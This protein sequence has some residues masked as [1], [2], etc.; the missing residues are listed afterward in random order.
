MQQMAVWCA[1]NTSFAHQTA[2]TSQTKMAVQLR[3][4]MEDDIRKLTLP[5]GIPNRVE[6]LISIVR[7]TFQL[8]GE[9]RLHYEDK[10]FNNQFF[11]VTSTADLYDKATVKIEVNTLKRK[12][13]V[14]AVPS[15]NVK[16]QKKAE[17]N[18]LPPHPIGESQDTLDKERL[19]LLNEVKKKNN[20][21][22]ITYKMRKTFSSRRL[23]VVTLRPSVNV[24]KER[25]PALFSEA[26]IKKEFRRITTVS[27]EDKFMK[28][29]DQ[30]TPGL[31]RVMRAK[32]GAAG[33]K[34]RPLLDTVNDTQI[35]EKK[36]DAVVCC[37]I[38]YFGEKR[39][40]LFYDCKECEDFTD[41]TIQVI[42]MHSNMAVEDP[43]D[44]S[45]VIEGNQ[46]MEGCGS[47]TKAC[48]LLMGLIY[49]LNLEYPKRLKNTFETFQKIFLELDRD[50]LPK[51]VDS[52]KKK[53]MQ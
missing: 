11:S 47:R 16:K 20:A 22:I 45:I 8:P 14:D 46:V 37:L 40:D 44:V 25:W 3:V 33:S 39:E 12:H 50:N 15:K 21:K 35:I 7:E 1:L 43:S 26:Q 51:K 10:E 9:F 13:P 4:I 31:L 52:L 24:I 49:A 29:L 36:R 23:E 53:L 38:D 6:D 2:K 41:K 19:E 34:M 30:Y 5:T 28:N 18:S 27:L 48:V 32:G 17:V 42:V